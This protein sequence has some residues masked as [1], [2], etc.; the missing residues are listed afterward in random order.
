[1]SGVISYPAPLYANV[2]IEPQYYTPWRFVISGITLGTTTT[3]NMVIPAITDLTYIVGQLV[4][5]IIPPTFGCRQLNGQ[6]AYVIAVNLPN[7]VILNIN[8]SQ[9]VDPYISSSAATSAQIL[10][11]G[12]ILAGAINNN[13]I[14]N[15]STV[16]PGSFI[17]VSP[18]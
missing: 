8:S 14:Q 12:D 2:P 3:V 16:L 11:I 5:L 18:N 10:A 7:Q 9:N 17:N 15:T 1:M 4:R 13:G 6:T